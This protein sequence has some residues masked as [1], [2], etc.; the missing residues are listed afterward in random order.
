MDWTSRGVSEGAVGD[1]TGVDGP[2]G[3]QRAVGTRNS[4]PLR[5]VHGAACAVQNGPGARAVDL[6]H[7]RGG[8]G[9]HSLRSRPSVA[10]L[11]THTCTYTHARTHRRTRSL[12]FSLPPSLP[13][14]PSLSGAHSP[15]LQPVGAGTRH[16]PPAGER[17]RERGGESS[18]L[19]CS[20]AYLQ[21]LL[22]ALAPGN[23]ALGARAA[24]GG[25]GSGAAVRV[26][27]VVAFDE[28]LVLVQLTLGSWERRRSSSSICWY[29]RGL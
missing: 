28:G 26:R 12:S 23:G 5:V 11:H 27:A 13:P 10:L 18:M 16:P 1:W 6:L 22:T 17:G 4:G 24:R 2:A 7:R 20:G 25:A 19:A 29:P 9:A 8:P 3:W 15:L 21:A 14:S